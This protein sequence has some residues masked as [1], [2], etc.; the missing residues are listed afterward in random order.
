MFSSRLKDAYF[1][2]KIEVATLELKVKGLEDELALVR[3]GRDR[4]DERAKEDQR[5]HDELAEKYHESEVKRAVLLERLDLLANHF[6]PAPTKPFNTMS[7]EQED[8]DYALHAGLIDRD[9]Y[10]AILA[11][12]GALNTEISFDSDPTRL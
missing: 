11:Q 2:A 9:E 10:E 5:K 6:P 4:M 7:E 12:A 8:A 1:E 3:A